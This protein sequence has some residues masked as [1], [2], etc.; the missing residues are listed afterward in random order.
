MVSRGTLANIHILCYRMEGCRTMY[1]RHGSLLSHSSIMAA[2]HGN[3]SLQ[4]ASESATT[5]NA[6]LDAHA[7]FVTVVFHETIFAERAR[8][9]LPTFSSVR[10]YYAHLHAAE[11]LRRSAQKRC[12]KRACAA[13]S[14]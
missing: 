4:K 3:R 1:I 9:F 13:C 14:I 7:P 6:W 5:A 8:Q 2:H 10:R 12:A 11:V